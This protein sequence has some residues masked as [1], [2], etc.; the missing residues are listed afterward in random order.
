MLPENI[1][2]ILTRNET[3]SGA[4]ASEPCECGWAREA[5][6]YI[7]A[8]KEP[9][10]PQPKARIEMS[11]DG[12][13]WLPEGTDFAMPTGKDAL[14]MARIRHFG[15]FLRVAADFAEGSSCTVLATL[16]LKA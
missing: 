13:H 6:L 14:A 15:N 16:H 7:R 8:L 5:V 9:I 3:W 1:T 11:P 2:A 12:I 4:A 10:G